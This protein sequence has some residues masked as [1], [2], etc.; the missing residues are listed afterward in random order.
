MLRITYPGG[1]LLGI[2]Y[3]KYVTTHGQRTPTIQILLHT[4]QSNCLS[5]VGTG[6]ATASKKKN[7]NVILALIYNICGGCV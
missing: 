6:D 1:K 5:G 2:A 3:R 7:E 4:E